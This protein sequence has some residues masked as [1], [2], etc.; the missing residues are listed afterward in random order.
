[1]EAFVGLLKRD[2]AATLEEIH[3]GGDDLCVEGPDG[4]YTHE[5]VVPLV[6]ATGETARDENSSTRAAARDRF[7]SVPRRFIPGSDWL[8]AKLYTSPELADE[9]LVDEVGPVTRELIDAGAAAG[10]FFIRFGDPDW[11]L[12]LRVHGAPERLRAEFLPELEAAVAP[13]I[14][15]GELWR[16]QLDSYEREVERYG[17]AEG[18]LVAEKVFNADSEAALG[19]LELLSGDEGADAR[20]R[21]ALRGMDMLLDDLGLDLEAK[22]AVVQAARQKFGRE[23]RVDGQFEYQLGDKYR[24]ER[25]GI[26]ALLD[27]N[28]DEE[29]ELAPGLRLLHTRS[30]KLRAIASELRACEAAGRL[31]VALPELAQSYLHMHANRM[32][33]SAARAQELVMYDF[34]VRTYESRLARA[35]QSDASRSI[36]SPGRAPHG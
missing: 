20:W 13:L 22:L 17:G 7:A 24:K 3:L 34:L 33:R 9:V 5:L 29:S 23:F 35:R 30:Q 36:P 1:V 26:E 21:F 12:R 18:L 32:L 19:I 2:T 16:L 8:Y 10:W 14:G 31:T 4:R 15:T 6:R 11:H 25:A 27:P 28:R